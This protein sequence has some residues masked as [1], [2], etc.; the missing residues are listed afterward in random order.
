M[1]ARERDADSSG[2]GSEKGVVKSTV[3]EETGN[4]SERVVVV[5][6]VSVAD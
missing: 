5:N 4:N 2:C 1:G 6:I 3:V